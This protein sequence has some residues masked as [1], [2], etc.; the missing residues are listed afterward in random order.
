MASPARSVSSLS[1]R[2]N[3]QAEQLG[4]DEVPKGFP[5]LNNTGSSQTAMLE[6]F[7]RNDPNW[8]MNPAMSEVQ[9]AAQLRLMMKDFDKTSQITTQREFVDWLQGVSK[10]NRYEYQYQN[11]PNQSKRVYTNPGVLPNG[12]PNENRLG[13]ER[14]GWN[15]THWGTKQLTHLPGVRDFLRQLQRENAEETF[16]ANMTADLGPTDINSAWDY[17]N[18][19]VK[20]KKWTYAAAPKVPAQAYDQTFRSPVGSVEPKAVTEDGVFEDSEIVLSNPQR[21]YQLQEQMPNGEF[22]P[23]IPKSKTLW[24]ARSMPN[25]EPEFIA[26]MEQYNDAPYRRPVSS[27]ELNARLADLEKLSE[28][29]SPEGDA[30]GD[31]REYDLSESETEDGSVAGVGLPSSVDGSATEEGSD[32]Q[33]SP[34]RVTPP[35]RQI[36]L[37]ILSRN[38]TINQQSLSEYDHEDARDLGARLAQDD[39]EATDMVVEFLDSINRP[40]TFET[41]PP[42]TPR[43]AATPTSEIFVSA[44]QPTPGTPAARIP[45]RMRGAGGRW[46]REDD[47]IREPRNVNAASRRNPLQLMRDIAAHAGTY[48][49]PFAHASPAYTPYTPR[50][51]PPVGEAAH[52]QTTSAGQG[53]SAGA[54]PSGHGGSRAP[55]DAL[56]RLD[57]SKFETRKRGG[58][59][60]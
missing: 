46:A 11:L 10:F 51:P 2:E 20:G 40:A 27:E 60:T 33:A 19:W 22:D 4:L 23:R 55:M 59:G 49:N 28:A 3:K 52:Y 45:G 14:E 54:G 39:P 57:K 8:D 56:N 42:K 6:D 24:D 1:Q 53:T 37:H 47:P 30:A 38:E 21:G 34:A 26:W 44:Q 17:F 58:K 35:L 7:M 50:T 5:D 48:V 12:E 43:R 31:E 25:A 16:A 29:T 32:T 18:T 9:Q 36:C 41:A 15:P 13:K